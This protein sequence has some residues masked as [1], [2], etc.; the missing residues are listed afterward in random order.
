MAPIGNPHGPR[1]EKP[2]TVSEGTRVASR[3]LTETFQ[4]VSGGGGFFV[5]PVFITAPFQPFQ[6]C[7]PCQ[8]DYSTALGAPRRTRRAGRDRGSS[9]RHGPLAPTL[10][11]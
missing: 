4:I 10:V 11:Y 1:N 6:C 9:A 3:P 7:Q 8:S 2:C 5:D